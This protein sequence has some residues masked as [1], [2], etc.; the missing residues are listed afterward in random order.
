MKILSC[1]LG[2]LLGYEDSI[3]GYIPSV[4]G[5]VI[6]NEAIEHHSTHRFLDLIESEQ[7]DVVPL[8]E[9]DRGS[10]RTRTDGQLTNILTELRARGL[11][12]HGHVYDKYG[13]DTMT[14]SFPIFRHLGNAVLLR[15]DLP[16]RPHYL[17]SGV[18]RLVIEVDLTPDTGLYVVHLSMTPGTRK[19][20]LADLATLISTRQRTDRVIIAGDFNIFDGLDELD[21]LIHQT[22]L[23]IHSPG[24]TVPERPIDDLVLSNRALDLFL[25]SPTITI[26]DSRIL[27]IQLS[28]HRPILLDIT[29]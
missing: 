18:K 6:G 22:E 16:T 24:E 23:V 20:Q 28:D 19:R 15:D 14:S 1:N 9:V 7:P 3:G 29:L 26:N 5:A 27:D 21:D 8:V 4:L 25:C 2:Y 12:Y 11:E 10:V 13:P 17:N